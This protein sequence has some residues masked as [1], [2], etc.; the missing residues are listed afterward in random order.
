[1]LGRLTVVVL[2]PILVL[3][4]RPASADVVELK[5]G[6][7]VEGA[8]KEATPAGVVIEVGGQSIRFDAANVRAIYFG[9]PGPPPPPPDAPPASAAAPA[10]PPPATPA[11]GALQIVQTLRSTV[12]AGTT[13]REYETRLNG[14]GPLMDLYLAGVQP[15]AGADALRDAMRYYVLA[16]WAWSNQGIVSRTVWLRKDDALARC[17]AYQEFARAMQAKGEAYYAER[18]RNYV[19]I[20]DGAV[21]VLWSCASE[22]ITE[23]E[24][25]LLKAEK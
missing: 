16:E 13:L 1:M 3:G 2:L 5:G 10:L 14:T 25:L 6:E 19:V 22:K 9:A 24:A 4:L 12:A 15:A 7:R 23:A 18:T 21:A 8:F 17:P 11:A 20:A